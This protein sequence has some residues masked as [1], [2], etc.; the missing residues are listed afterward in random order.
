MLPGGRPAFMPQSSVSGVISDALSASGAAPAIARDIT[1]PVF[2]SYTVMKPLPAMEFI[3][4]SIMFN[5]A[6]TA[7]AA[8]TALP[9]FIST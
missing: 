4:G 6:P 8:S 2:L 3:C 9:P 7:T 5:V 1:L